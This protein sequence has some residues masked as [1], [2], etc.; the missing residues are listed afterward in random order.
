MPTTDTRTAGQITADCAEELATQLADLAELIA[1]FAPSRAMYERASTVERFAARTGKELARLRM[2]PAGL[3]TN[4]TAALLRREL[5]ELG[6]VK[7]C[8]CS[9]CKQQREAGIPPRPPLLDQ[10]PGPP[11]PYPVDHFHVRAEL[12][13]IAADL[14]EPAGPASANRSRL[15]TLLHYLKQRG[16]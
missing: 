12:E 13:K 14:A 6:P 15:N 1:E 5:A 2:S 10:I 11:T 8:P 16:Y 3:A 9:F 7:G 4:Q